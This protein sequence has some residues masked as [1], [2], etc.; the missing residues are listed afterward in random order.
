MDAAAQKVEGPLQV[1]VFTLEGKA[2]ALDIVQVQEI[3]RMVEIT[4][5]PKMPPFALG[6]INLRGKIVPII[7]IREKLNLPDRPATAK[8]SIVLMRSGDRLLGF[9]ADDVTEVMTLPGGSIDKPASGPDWIQS[10]L[11]LGV[12]KLPGTLL[13]IIDGD[14]LLSPQEEKLLEKARSAPLPVP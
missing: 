4:P 3:I 10:D 9:L 8:T 7:N 1:V 5:V 12:G 11:F 14:R 2:L 6:V 13:V